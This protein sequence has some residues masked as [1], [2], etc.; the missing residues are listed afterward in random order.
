[1]MG[2]LVIERTVLMRTSQYNL[3]QSRHSKESA[4]VVTLDQSPSSYNETSRLQVTM[5]ILK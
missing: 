4:M 3:A 2:E 1:M 5:P